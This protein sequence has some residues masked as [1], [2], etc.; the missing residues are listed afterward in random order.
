[1]GLGHQNFLQSVSCGSDVLTDLRAT[2]VAGNLFIALLSSFG[3]IS[4]PALG[5]SVISMHVKCCMKTGFGGCP[6]CP[7]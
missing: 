1:M 4:N 2:I 6:W 3:P 7:S 5:G